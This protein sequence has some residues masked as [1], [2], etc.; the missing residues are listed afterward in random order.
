[1]YTAQVGRRGVVVSTIEES[2]PTRQAFHILHAMLSIAVVA[3]G[4]DKF[5]HLLA[6]WDACV[7]PQVAN[8]IA[9]SMSPHRFMLIAGIVEIALGVLAA[10]KPRAG[11]AVLSMWLVATVVNVALSR[12]HLDIVLIGLLLAAMAFAVSR[13]ATAYA[14]V[15]NLPG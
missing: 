13:L 10:V 7:A 15:T 9:A 11:G 1:M 3:L 4:V 14:R 12:H 6:D 8:A 2:V 5:F